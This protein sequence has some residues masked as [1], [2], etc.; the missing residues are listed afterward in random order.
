M[1]W[2][3]TT[4]RNVEEAKEAALDQL[5]VDESDTEFIVISEPRGGLFGRIR[6]EARVRA[7]VR[8]TNPRPKRARAR[9]QSQESR[10]QRRPPGGDASAK[11]GS[12]SQGT[13][14]VAEN[15]RAEELAE[16]N[17][18][19]M[20]SAGQDVSENGT[21]GGETKR[22]QRSRRRRPPRGDRP[23]AVAGVSAQSVGANGAG[24]VST[25][26]G[27]STLQAPQHEGGQG[28]SER[29]GRADA[30]KEE[31]VGEGLSLEEQGESAREFV[32][33]LVHLLEL[34]GTVTMS[35][36]DDSTV[37]VAVDGPELGILVGPGGGT[38]AAV[39][40]LAR[41]VVQ[42][43]TGGRSERILVDVAGYRVKRAAALQR[44]T[45]QVVEEVLANLSERAL[46]PMSASDRKVV[47]DTVNEIEGVVTRSVGEEPRR[48]IVVAPEPAQSETLGAEDG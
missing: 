23:P 21:S 18:T 22:S 6:G 36:V 25:G 32:E 15:E 47:H 16:V 28:N 12:R 19:P 30:T 11:E 26:A 7:R 44:F 20:G 39:Q 24:T 4:G 9:R 46:E 1:E 42:R 33:G 2:V 43:R 8:P 5:G 48:Y 10:G 3:E 37:Q 45:R 38:L 41:T 29:S 13:V 40:E 14:S 35:V 27:R 34:P 31:A 17:E